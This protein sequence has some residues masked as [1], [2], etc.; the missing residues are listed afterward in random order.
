MAETAMSDVAA[1]DV[2]VVDQPLRGAVRE[3]AALRIQH[4]ARK[5]ARDVP[6]L[7]KLRRRSAT[8]AVWAEERYIF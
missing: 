4:A 8:C 2:V 1:D 5:S 6:R 7:R 3:A